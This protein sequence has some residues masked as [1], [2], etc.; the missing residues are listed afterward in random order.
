MN[1][2]VLGRE[3]LPSQIQ[4]I[5]PLMILLY[6]PLFNGFSL[7]PCG[8]RCRQGWHFAGVYGWVGRRV[9][10][11][12]LR[13]MGCGFFLTVLAF[14]LDTIIQIWIADGQTPSVAW[15]FCCYI[16]LTAAE[17]RPTSYAGDWLC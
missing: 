9:A 13:K 3:W 15:L 10:L 12:P 17:V 14:G 16:I 4:A 8:R 2:V 5:N 11:T 6:V 7:G 1:R